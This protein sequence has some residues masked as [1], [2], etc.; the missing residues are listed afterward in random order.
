LKN[1]LMDFTEFK[2]ARKSHKVVKSLILYLTGI[3][4]SQEFLGTVF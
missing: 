1:V 2:M 3:A 4:S